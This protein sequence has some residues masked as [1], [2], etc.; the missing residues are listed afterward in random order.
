MKKRT[1]G[2]RLEV[3]AIG[4]GC[5]GMSFAYGHA[6]EK[7]SLATID[8]GLELGLN[9][10]DTA[11][12]YGPHTNEELLAKAI[13]GRRDKFVIATKFGI[14][15]KPEGRT[16]TGTPEYARQAVEGSLKRLGIDVIDL[17][18]LHRVDPNTP[19][20][21]TV[22]EMARLK[23]QG[24]IRN[25]GLSEA[26]AETLRRAYKIH[27]ITALQSEY[28]LWTRDVEE[29]GVLDAARELGVSLV[30]YSPLGRGFLSGELK[31]FD[32]FAADD[33]RRTN[34]RFQG[35]NFDKNLQ[36]VGKIKEIAAAKGCTAAQLAL[37]WVLAQDENLVPI[38]GTTKAKRIEENIG[39]ADL[40]LTADELK[41]I[42]D[43]FPAG[44]AAGPRYQPEMMRSVNA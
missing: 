3:S 13:S 19:I 14:Q 1:L 16:I 30:P 36:L 33:F 41:A 39:A 7:E 11:D 5:M 15:D 42:D 18:Y 8:R 40:D 23:E 20:E 24:K 2:G 38:P 44:A 32:D 17:Y 22:G 31:S 27:P 28:S 10:L 37:A 29:N 35:E 26:S 6:D 21:D 9:F 43:I 25:I 12:I 4:L 34:P